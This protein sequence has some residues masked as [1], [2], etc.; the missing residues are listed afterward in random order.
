MEQ[1]LQ[2]AVDLLASQYGEHQR[3]NSRVFVTQLYRHL[4]AEDFSKLK[5][6]EIE[7]GLIALFG[8]FVKRSKDQSVHNV[9]Y[10]HPKGHSAK[11]ERIVIDV[12]NDDRSFLV[13]SLLALLSRY[14]LRARILMH[15]VFDVERDAQGMLVNLSPTNGAKLKSTNAESVI[16]CEVVESATPDLVDPIKQMIDVV[17]NDVKAAN[18]DWQSMRLKIDE[19]IEDL[20][21][22]E[23]VIENKQLQEVLEFLSWIKD[24]HFTF[25]GYCNF[26]LTTPEGRLLRDPIASSGLGILSESSIQT[27]SALYE[28]IKFNSVA[29]RYIHEPV[30]LAI[31]KT[32]KISNV[33]RA[34]AMD[35]LWVKRF[36]KRGQ[37]VGIHVFTGLFTSIAYDSSARDIPLLKNKIN[38]ILSHSNLSPG[39]HDGKSLIHI[40][41]SL[42]RDELFQASVPELSHIGLSV[43]KLQQRHRVALFIRR[44]QFNRFLSC[45]V[46][47]PREKFDTDLCDKFGDILASE[48]QG[49]VSAYKAQ[50]GALDFARVHYTVQIKDGAF[51]GVQQDEIERK[52]IDIARSWRDELRVVLAD[53]YTETESSRLYRRYKEAFTKGYQERFSPIDA[54][55]DIREIEA[56]LISKGRRA[57]LSLDTVR[58]GQRVKLKIYNFHDP[59]ALSEILPTLENMDLRIIS[60]NPFRVKIKDVGHEIWMHD[61]EAEVLSNAPID[62]TV[63]EEKFLETLSKCWSGVIENDGFNRLVLR[64]ALTSR[65]CSLLRAYCKYIRQLPLPFGKDYI[66]S[67]LIAN[68]K[69]AKKLVTLFEARFNPDHKQNDEGLI[70]KIEQDLEEIS[71]VDVDRILRIY[72]NLI[73]ATLRTNFYQI[74]ALGEPKSYIS[75]KFECSKVEELPL[76]K[77]MYE[78]FVYSSRMEAVHLR[79]GKVARGGIRWSD[80][81]EDFRTEVLGL[82]KAQ[83]VKNTVI[84]PVGSK[85][86]FIVKR[87]LKTMTREQFLQE[88][89]E[90]YQTMIRGMLDIT[91]NFV[92][93]EIIHPERVV[94]FDE[95]D[96]YLVVAADKGTATFSDFANAVS[97]E[98]NF[99]LDD[100]FASGGSVG[101]DHK[102]M[103]ITARGAWESVKRHFREMGI[104][105]STTS[106]TVIGVGDMSGDVFG[107]G[108]LST[109]TLKLMFAFDHRHIFIDPDPDPVKSF[110]ERARLF[111]L[112]RS[113]WMDYDPDLISE[114]GGVYDRNAKEIKLS[115]K[116]RSLLNISKE[117]VTPS[118]LLQSILKFKADLLWLG[119]IGTFIKSSRESHADVGDRNNDTIRINGRELQ[120]HVVG[121]GANLGVTQLGRIEYAALGGRINTDAID[122]SAGVDCSDHEVN[123]KILLNRLVLESSLTLKD[124]NSLLEKM[125][126]DVAHLVLRDNYLQTMALSMSHDRRVRDLDHHIKIMHDLEKLGRL[127]RGIEFL[128]DDATL[129]DFQTD[130]EGLTRPELA[131]LMAYVKIHLFDLFLA[132][133]LPEEDFFESLLLDYFPKQLHKK[134]HQAIL[135]HPL[136]REIIATI[137]I[138]ELINRIGLSFVY[139]VQEKCGCAFEDVI[140]VCYVVINVFDLRS[141]WEEVELLDYKVDASSQIKILQDM[142]K[143]IVRTII[144][145]LRY[146]PKVTSINQTSEALRAGVEAFLS[147][148]A[149]CLDDEGYVALGHSVADYQKLG[150]DQDLSQRLSILKI[151]AS[152]PDIILI[153]SETGYTVAEVAELYFK[154]GNR[155]GFNVL[156]HALEAIGSNSFWNRWAAANLQEDLARYHNK[157]VADILTTTGSVDQNLDATEKTAWDHWMNRYQRQVNRVDQV[158]NEA[159]LHGFSDYTMVSVV[160]REIREIVNA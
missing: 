147:S 114:G 12:V 134:Y 135:H 10:W 148:L 38:E 145:I 14:G 28:G 46:Y 68:P 146:Y 102:K 75:F 90:C 43:L 129:Q 74:D 55:Y 73:L 92:A 89:V 131:V 118:Q 103:G 5:V 138:N 123:I 117:K 160:A 31:N 153:A 26:D 157:M 142:N 22:S 119:G 83:M 85:G 116:V 56:V 121:E 35:S 27:L 39:W 126:D 21:S 140:K 156:K 125:T 97:K 40:L 51:E 62:L 29:R 48:F 150:L 124:R 65:Q 88:G 84:V 45:L 2:K 13:D 37:V 18:Q 63:V 132:S 99:W 54:L 7:E 44:D 86:G 136:R 16:H 52:L 108:M 33:H 122:N 130:Q 100:A 120:V 72:F 77:P 111:Q 137:S 149:A 152:S 155:F 66:E 93:S 60:E 36:N 11:S 154:V 71:S 70:Q 151:A 1:L 133:S 144:W 112:P 127:N 105:V 3:E 104:D 41:D 49:T 96:P 23:D 113:S 69:I 158:L 141:F 64:A 110:N 128:P 32:S 139:E 61:F 78:I 19:A 91:D 159:K 47:V 143:I 76:P 79:G 17:Y 50:F 80:R 4:P 82:M 94:R 95:D 8:L 20:K 67:A 15:P 30:P 25:L 81:I 42:P 59:V 101:Y 87:D 106:I 34:V 24:D 109:N 6:E 53:T 107:N 9:Y 115:E 98:Y 57:R 58:Q